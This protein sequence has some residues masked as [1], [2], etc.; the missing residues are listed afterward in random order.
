MGGGTQSEHTNRLVRDGFPSDFTDVRLSLRLRGELDLRGAQ[1][2]FQIWGDVDGISSGYTLISQPINVTKD[3]STQTIVCNPDPTQWLSMGGRHDRSAPRQ[4]FPQTY[5][6]QGLQQTLKSCEDVMLVLFPI[7]VQPMGNVDG[8]PN[9]LRPQ[10]DY[11]VWRHKLPEGYVSLAK[12][13]IEWP[14]PA[15]L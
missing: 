15:K 12:V 6:N 5:G 11:P 4:P 8:D 9:E 13:E 2:F 14:A 1:V 7:D 10:V 3:W